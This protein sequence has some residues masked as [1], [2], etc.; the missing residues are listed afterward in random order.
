MVHDHE[1][2]EEFE[3]KVFTLVEKLLLY[4]LW[5]DLYSVYVVCWNEV[6]EIMSLYFLCVCCRNFYM[7]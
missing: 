6:T 5:V 7:I 4:N 2:R 3:L 1:I